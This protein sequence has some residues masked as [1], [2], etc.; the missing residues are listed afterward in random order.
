MGQR[1]GVIGRTRSRLSRGPDRLRV[2]AGLVTGLVAGFAAVVFAASD[3]PPV[4]FFLLGA[5]VG[6]VVFPITLLLMTKRY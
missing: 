4:A 2:L 3:L 6:A 1:Q 5:A